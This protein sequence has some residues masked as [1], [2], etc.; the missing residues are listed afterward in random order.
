[1][2]TDRLRLGVAGLGRAFT[3]MLP[4]FVRHPRVAL[5]AAADPRPEARSHF[6]AEFGARAY[7]TVEA[8]CADPEIDAV[9][10]ASPHQFHVDHVRLA[11]AHGK[12]V[13][14]EKPMALTLDDCAAMVAAARAAGVHLLVGHSHSF[15]LPYRR[16]RALID[17][18]EF[19]AVR[20]IT[21]V[22][23]TDYL[24]RPRRPEELDTAQGGG[25]LFSQAP[26]QIE[27]VRLLAGSPA[28]SVRA[29]AGRWD[30]ARPTE[31]AY[32]AH[33]S[34]AD[35]TFASLTYSGYGHFDTDALQGWTGE[36][37]QRRDPEAYGDARRALR[38]VSDAQAEAALKERRAYGVG[39][40]PAEALR[41]APPPHAHNHFGLVVVCCER[42]DLRPMPDRVE[43]FADD[44]R[45]VEMLPAPVVPRG[46]V[47]DEL[48]GAVL[49]GKPPLHTGEWGMAT[50]EVVLALHASAVAG[51]EMTLHHQIGL[52]GPVQ[53]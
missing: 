2:S 41:A 34:F 53:A 17:T 22:N 4:T 43:V 29:S 8:L 45:R 6:A 33:L 21:A 26:H 40:T 31:G 12:H 11:A 20:M 36:L 44:E 1:M 24:Y 47:V 16:T 5:A 48:A 19:G 30:P 14:V 15:D 25:A 37:G 18:G 28:A 46:E 9:Y 27:I 10:V 32:S 35:G 13:L 39:F 51:L 50:T 3:L 38:G 7:E 52:P 49:D 23:F 42:G